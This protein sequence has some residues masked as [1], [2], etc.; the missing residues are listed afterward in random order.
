MKASVVYGGTSYQQ[1]AADLDTGCD[2][3]VATP[4]RLADMIAREKVSLARVKFLCIDEVDRMLDLGFEKDI[5]KIV[6]G[7]DLPPRG[8]RQTVLFSATIPKGKALDVIV[9]WMRKRGE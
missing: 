7:A 4:G 9:V 5:R 1:Q 2:I 8:S 6:E 3:L